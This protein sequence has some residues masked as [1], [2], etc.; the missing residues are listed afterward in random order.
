MNKMNSKEA[1]ILY[2]KLEID[3]S[4]T[5]WFKRVS[6]I[7]GLHYKTLDRYFYTHREFIE[8]KRTFDKNDKVISRVE[9]LQQKELLDPSKYGLDIVGMTT[10]VA[11][12]TQW[13]KTSKESQNKALF[14][15]NK[16]TIK[17]SV[18]E[19]DLKPLNVPKIK[20]SWDK[21]LKVTY[22]D[23][24]VGLD[25]KENLYGLRLWNEDALFDALKSIVSHVKYKFN[26]HSKIVVADYGDFM[27]GW[28]GQTTRKGHLLSQNMDNTKAFEVGTKFKIELAK[29]LSQ[30]GVPIEF[31]SI[32][33]DNHSGSFAEIVNFHVQEVLS[34][35]LPNVKYV[36][37][38]DMLNH[39]FINKFC[40]ICT[41]GKDA[42]HMKFGF[43][44]KPDEKSKGHINTYIDKH[45]LHDF[46]IVFEMGDRH[47]LI[48]DNSEYKF[49]YNVYY[50][51]SPAS[52]WIQTNFGKGIRGFCIEEI[53]GKLKTF[54][55]I[56][57]D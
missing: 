46:D 53:E 45:G 38:K 39:Y 54:L 18:K 51:L 31:Y 37:F 9:K 25:I 8:V 27:D 42:K 30:F 13:V 47:Q 19:L 44:T 22:T 4:N 29:E 36:T 52:D 48:R 5:K 32:T 56:K 24:H 50:A 55:P 23:A 2:P 26:G 34:Y 6:S 21:V 20:P 1:L 57:L 14:E 40:I 7:T 11:H 41:H 43:N 49:E 17:Q 35:I 10:N 3:K 33:N 12:G 15:L 28:D 16:E